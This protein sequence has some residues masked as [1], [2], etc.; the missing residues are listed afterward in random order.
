MDALSEAAAEYAKLF[1]RD[2]IYTLATGID[3][4]VY[5]IPGFFHHLM[6]LQKLND[7]PSLMKSPRNNTNY[8]FRNIINGIITLD[9]IGKS[10]YFN[11]IEARLKH[12]SQINRIIEFEEIIVD[13]NP[14]LL[15]SSKIVEAD[16][17]LFKRSNDNMY[18]NLFLKSDEKNG[19]A[20]IPLTFIPHKTDYYTYGQKVIKIL[21]M[22]E[23]ARCTKQKN[24]N[25][26]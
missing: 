2:F 13:F 3:I 11:E 8:I 4:R 26:Q 16:Y 25:R 5:F 12:F 9:E 15:I 1:N 14:S 6:G 10:Q 22:T 24:K 21:S 18:L 19:M 23:V 20:Q 7:I 17:V